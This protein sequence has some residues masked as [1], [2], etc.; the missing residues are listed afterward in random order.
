MGETLTQMSVVKDIIFL[1]K[2]VDIK[3]NKIEF[4]K[5]RVDT[6][7]DNLIEKNKSILTYI[8]N[9]IG[10]VEL[11]LDNVDNNIKYYI[12]SISNDTEINDW[13]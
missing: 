2:L 3:N 4:I 12:Y 6:F 11:N 9:H 5:T 13:K 10:S 7:I 1:I 8:K